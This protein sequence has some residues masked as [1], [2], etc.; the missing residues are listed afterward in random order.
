MK[1]WIESSFLIGMVALAAYLDIRY[2]KISNTYWLWAFLV[3]IAMELCLYQKLS[4]SVGG[5]ILPFAIHLLPFSMGLVYAG[6]VKLFMVV[7]CF[8]GMKFISLV[9]L[10]AYIVGG[11]VALAW[12]VIHNNFGAR[13][14]RIFLFFKICFM[15]RKGINYKQFCKEKDGAVDAKREMPFALNVFVATVLLLLKGGVYGII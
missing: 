8:S 12:M 6:D 5:L 11:I 14:R 7:G 15:T 1:I 9:M 3:G 10:G 2:R 4:L 13:M